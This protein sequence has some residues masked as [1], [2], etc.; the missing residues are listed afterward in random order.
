LP[1]L[2][3]LP[4]PYSSV[5]L[6]RSALIQEKTFVPADEYVEWQKLSYDLHDLTAEATKQFRLKA[7]YLFGSRRFKTLSLRSDI[8][9]FFVPTSYI[10]QS[11]LRRFR[12]ETCLALDIFLL[13]HGRATSAINDSYIQLDDDGAVI[14]VTRAVKLWSEED[15]DSTDPDISWIQEYADHVNFRETVL[16]NVRLVRSLDNLKARLDRQGLP[17][18]V[19]VG[20]SIRLVI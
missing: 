1:L 15:G 2:Q 14:E 17:T 8:D 16:P 6:C 18:A 13:E 19:V 7:I 20:N 4:S 10:K 9:V 11:D 3:T 12:D 5:L